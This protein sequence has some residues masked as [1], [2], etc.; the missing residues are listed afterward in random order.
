LDLEISPDG[1]VWDWDLVQGALTPEL[2]QMILFSRFQPATVFGQ[3]TWGELR[4]LFRHE[5]RY[6]IRG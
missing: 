6:I 4:V 3:P 5:Y 2:K 1:K